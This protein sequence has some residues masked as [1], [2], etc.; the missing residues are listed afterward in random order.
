MSLGD[1]A[2]SHADVREAVASV[3]EKAGKAHSLL[4]KAAR[5]VLA[6]GTIEEAGHWAGIGLLG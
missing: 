2:W 5:A 6:F 4:L 1:I 3:R